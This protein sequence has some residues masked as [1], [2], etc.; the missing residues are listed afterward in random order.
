MSIHFFDKTASFL[1]AAC[2]IA[3]KWGNTEITLRSHTE[4]KHRIVFRNKDIVVTNDG[5]Y[6]HLMIERHGCSLNFCFFGDNTVAYYFREDCI[7]SSFRNFKD[8]ST[9]YRL[10]NT[11]IDIHLSKDLPNNPD[12]LRVFQSIMR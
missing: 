2:F 6:D 1:G 11:L 10:F 4:N 12:K 7:Q 5:R 9:C 3:G 8:T